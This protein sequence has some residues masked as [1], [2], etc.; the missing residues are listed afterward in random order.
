MQ[1]I[2]DYKKIN[3]K[4]HGLISI[5][6]IA[7]QIIDTKY[8]QRLRNVKQLGTCSFIFPSATHTRFEHSIGVYHLAGRLMQCIMDRTKPQDIEE[9]LLSVPELRNYFVRTYNGYPLLDKYIC[10][11][12]KIGGL[13][14]DIAHGPF[15]HSFDDVFLKN[16]NIQN[17]HETRGGILIEKIIKDNLILS[18]IIQKPEIDFIKNIINPTDK[19]KG[20]L[21]QVVSN[22]LN[23][24]D[25]DKYDYI[26]RDSTFCGIPVGFDFTRLIN[27]VYIIDNNICYSKQSSFEIYRM[28]LSRYQ[29]HHQLYHHKGVISFQLMIV[30]LMTLLDPYIKLSESINDVDSFNKFTDSYILECINF[31]D[32]N[33]PNIQKAQEIIDRIQNHKLYKHIETQFSTKQINEPEYNQ[34]YVYHTGCIGFVSGKKK[35]PL[36]NIF[37]YEYK[38]NTRISYKIELNDISNIMPSKFQEYYLMKFKK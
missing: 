24:C 37:I 9:Y 32:H 26:V 5:S 23:S 21:F 10:E 8:F 33:I 13:V 16:K 29:L 31:L 34:E 3:D 11:L 22:Y 25:V 17:T 27:D 28:Y 20:F 15:S 35:N 1:L 2:T 18:Q 4:I 6:N 36:T 38:D 12:V 7:I 14:H 30:E 19:N